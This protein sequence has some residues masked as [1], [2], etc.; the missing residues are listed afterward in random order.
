VDIHHDAPVDASSNEVLG[1]AGSI[2]ETDDGSD[3]VEQL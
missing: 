2:V 1:N 3:R